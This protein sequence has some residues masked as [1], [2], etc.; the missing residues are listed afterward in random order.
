M[1]LPEISETGCEPSRCVSLDGPDSH[2]HEKLIV[3]PLEKALLYGGTRASGCD[4][5]F[6]MF[7]IPDDRT[8]STYEYTMSLPSVRHSI[9]RKRLPSNAYMG[10]ERTRNSADFLKIRRSGF[11]SNSRSAMK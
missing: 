5:G 6:S 1:L 9:R 4:A 2:F 11:F 10:V 7:V 8:F 3:K